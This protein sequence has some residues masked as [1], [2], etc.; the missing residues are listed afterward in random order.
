MDPLNISK[1][2]ETPLPESSNESSQAS[3]VSIVIPTYD[4][5]EYLKQAIESAIRQTYQNTEIIISDNCS[6]KSP[7]YIVDS[8]Q[9]P[10]IRFHQNEKNLGASANIRNSMMLAKGKYV[11]SLHDD[12]LWRPNFLERLVFHLET[13]S[14]LVLAF[15]DEYV[16]DSAGFVNHTKTKK[17]SQSREKLEEGIYRPFYDLVINQSMPAFSGT[18]IKRDVVDWETW[19]S[20]TDKVWGYMDYCL[21]YFCCR[22]G[23]GIYY[24]PEKLSITRDHEETWSK[25]GA[26]NFDGKIKAAKAE[27]FYVKLLLE[28]E[29]TRPYTSHLL[30][31]LAHAYTSLGIGLLR[32]KKLAE[33]RSNL[34]Y[35]LNLNKFSLKTILA[36]I[37]SYLTPSKQI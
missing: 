28:D 2:L 7:Q 1:L 27:I 16:I 21:M 31:R 30:R 15:S 8:F 14:D 29:K 3:L 23:G 6:P 26:I 25:K 20:L 35:S 34:F 4:R 19:G 18:V 22:S 37:L 17:A 5:P 11:A 10:R 12:N 13:N 36:L 24:V 33:A 32:G 9:D